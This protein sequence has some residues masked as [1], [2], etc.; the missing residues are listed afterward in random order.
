MDFPKS[1]PNVG[2]VDGRFVD[3]S[4][5]TGQ[6]G[7]L[8]TAEW[9]NA[10]TSEIINVIE[11]AELVPTEG[12]NDQLVVAIEKLTEQKVEGWFAKAVVQAT[13]SVRGWAK[14]ATQTLTDAGVDDSTF[15]TPKKLRRGVSYI[16]GPNGYVALPTWLGGLI[17]QWGTVTVPAYTSV[18]QFTSPLTTTYPSECY[19]VVAMN[20][21]SVNILALVS[22]TT[23]TFTMGANTRDQGSSNPVSSAFF[24][25][26]GV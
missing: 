26:L 13:E 17:L 18:V 9:G 2:L 3:E 4:N 20:M 8:I 10:M 1:V 24:I 14:V 15:V 21:T 23:S 22:K 19:G 6:V 7:S 25:S 11:A 16:I 12:Q 5:V